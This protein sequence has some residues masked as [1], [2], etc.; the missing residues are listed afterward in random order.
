[1]GILRS[2]TARFTRLGL[3]VVYHVEKAELAKVPRQGPA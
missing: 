2:I 3:G 1:M